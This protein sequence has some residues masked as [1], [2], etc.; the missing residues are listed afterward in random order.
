MIA[1][2][3]LGNPGGEYSLTRHNIGYLVVDFLVNKY[4]HLK[5]KENQYY[6]L[7]LH[8][9]DK[10]NI[11]FVKPLVFM[12]NSGVVLKRL[13]EEFE[14]QL[15]KTL[16]ICDDFNLPLGKIRMRK[17][18][19]DGGQKGLASIIMSLN[20][21]HIPRLRCGIGFREDTDASEYVLS[22]FSEAQRDSVEKM[23]QTAGKAVIDFIHKGIDRTMNNYN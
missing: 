19:S 23:I 7:F 20:N 18:G 9:K 4:T 5:R 13:I 2:V 17:K 12:N 15:H 11:G 1:I 16:I 21:D 22:P 10:E 3:G 6:E 14:L 8:T